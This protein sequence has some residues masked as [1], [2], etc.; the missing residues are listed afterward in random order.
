MKHTHFN[1][2]FPCV[3]FY[4]F[5]S[6]LSGLSG[7]KV[8]NLIFFQHMDKVVHLGLFFLLGLVLTR[9]FRWEKKKNHVGRYAWAYFLVLGVVMSFCNE[10]L[11]LF[12]KGREISLLDIGANILGVCSGWIVYVGLIEKMPHSLRESLYYL[13]L[14]ILFLFLHVS[15]VFYGHLIL[16]YAVLIWVG[17]LCAR[18]YS[19]TWNLNLSIVSKS[20]QFVLVAAGLAFWVVVEQW[21]FA[22]NNLEA[23]LAPI[24]ISVLSG[25]FIY[26]LGFYFIKRSLKASSSSCEFEV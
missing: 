18:Y 24:I 2:W 12:Q 17:V 5:L 21:L 3:V 8:S 13:G 10:S 20:M 4:L 11:Q 15:S 14:P 23:P 7:A 9:A 1:L 16:S 26:L 25:A 19:I 6:S 22:Y